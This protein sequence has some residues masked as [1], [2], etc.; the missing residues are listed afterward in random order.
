M[1][2][3]KINQPQNTLTTMQVANELG[4]THDMINRLWRQ[5]IIKG[6]KKNPFA[7]NSP[8]LIPASELEKLKKAF[9]IKN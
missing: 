2:S 4:V 5:G 1:R 9:D 7:R 8:V 6:K 3:M